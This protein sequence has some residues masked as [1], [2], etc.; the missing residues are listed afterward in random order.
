[1][2]PDA[3]AP[4]RHRGIWIWSSTA[5]GHEAAVLAWV[6]LHGYTDLFLLVK[7]ASG[8]VKLDVLD[9][10]LVLRGKAPQAPRIWAWMVGFHDAS[11]ADAA[12]TYLTGDWVSPDSA[13]YRAHLVA[14]AREALDPASGQVTQVADGLMLDDT[15]QW[16]SQSYGGTTTHRVQSLMQVVDSLQAV[17]SGVQQGTGRPI[18]LGAAPHPE[19]S[20]SSKSSGAIVTAAAY[21]YGQDFGELAKRCDW[22]VPETYRYGFYGHGAAWIGQVVADVKQEIALECP[23]RRALVEVFPALVLYLSDTDPSPVTVTDLASD[24][25]AALAEAGGFS[26]FRF[27]SKSANPGAGSDGR[28]WPTAAQSQVLDP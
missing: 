24:R 21:A 25:A 3:A 16:P 26:V 18:L 6:R 10:L 8:V 19:T 28:D 22:L 2:R 17:A 20:V 12:W 4:A 11:H 5:R 9:K 15:F 27:A 23:A 14:V 1:M 13:A 7:G